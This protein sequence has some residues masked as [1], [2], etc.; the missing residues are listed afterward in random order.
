MNLTNIKLRYTTNPGYG[1]LVVDS[2]ALVVAL[3]NDSKQRVYNDFK[4]I[5][6]P[7]S[8]DLAWSLVLALMFALLRHLF[9]NILCQVSLAKP[10]YLSI[11][12]SNL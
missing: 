2:L 1:D 3:V 9:Q 12:G 11:E 8:V 5:F 6:C 4:N 7:S 10:K